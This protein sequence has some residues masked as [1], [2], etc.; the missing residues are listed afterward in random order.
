MLMTIVLLILYLRAVENNI[1]SMFIKEIMIE[2]KIIALVLFND[3]V[4][5]FQEERSHFFWDDCSSP[6]G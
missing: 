6:A 3:V 4:N 2:K 1:K 5:A